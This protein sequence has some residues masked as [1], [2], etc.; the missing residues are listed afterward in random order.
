MFYL[1]T[2]GK[3]LVLGT[4][5]W[6]W[7]IERH[8]A[9]KI[10]EKFVECGGSMVDTATN[11]PINKRADDHGL[12]LK[13]LAEWLSVNGLPLSIMIKIGSVDNMGSET[14]NL[15]SD[16]ILHSADHFRDKLG[17]AFSSIAIH[18]DNRSIEDNRN[19][20]IENTVSAM[21]ALE[22]SGIAIGLSGIKYPELYYKAN[23]AL[24]E[25]WI[26][27][28]KENAT[29][30]A[31]RERYQCFFPQAKYLAYSI[32][33]GGVKIE[34]PRHDSSIALRD[35][36]I[37][38]STIDKLVDFLKSDHGLEPKPNSLNELALIQSYMNPALSG[39]I[40]SP[41]NVEQLVD[42]LCF[43]KKLQKL[44]YDEM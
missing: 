13:W 4:A 22:A 44:N 10:L 12:A 37:P 17:E 35:I 3:V 28:V 31:D 11:Y 23:P 24:S 29:T 7:G 25:K 42:T 8:E 38:Q 41:R 26:I 6:G 33:L 15:T 2:K 19:H 40:I 32:N 34:A 30:C 9:Y 39:V 14:T 36:H 18:W 1:P 16:N 20:D 21:T 43:W 27:Q 5:L